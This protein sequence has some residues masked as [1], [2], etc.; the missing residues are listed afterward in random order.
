MVT[1]QAFDGGDF[2]AYLAVP[3]SGKGP[4]IV[5]LQE[6]FGVNN[7]MRNIADHYAELGFTVIC[8]DL[9]WRQ[10]P[11]IQLT[12]QTD[13]GWKRAFELYHGLDEA[14]AID[15]AAAAMQVLRSHPACTGK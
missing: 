9:F 4:G 11:G 12:D 1:V 6:I 13:A 10:E 8:P 2:E 3:T 7:V 14:K 15:D 5:L